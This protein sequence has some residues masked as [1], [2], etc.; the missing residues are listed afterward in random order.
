MLYENQ[1]LVV[2]NENLHEYMNAMRNDVE[3][4]K[5]HQGI[6]NQD[7]SKKIQIVDESEMISLS[8]KNE[9]YER[10]IVKLQN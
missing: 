1:K 4:S 5:L 2:Y 9:I 7:S 10:D 8:H 6:I 3:I